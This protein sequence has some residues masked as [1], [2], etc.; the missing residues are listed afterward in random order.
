MT[1]IDLLKVPFS[2]TVVSSLMISQCY[3]SFCFIRDA[4][5]GLLCPLPRGTQVNRLYVKG[6]ARRKRRAILSALDHLVCSIQFLKVLV[7]E[8]YFKLPNKFE[9]TNIAGI[10]KNI[11]PGAL[12]CYM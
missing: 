5:V 3:M 11:H 9:R 12:H 8:Q 4:C 2:A 6:I 7:F 10:T 1:S